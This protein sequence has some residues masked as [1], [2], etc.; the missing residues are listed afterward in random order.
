MYSYCDDTCH[1]ELHWGSTICISLYLMQLLQEIIFRLVQFSVL[2]PKIVLA[3]IVP[4]QSTWQNYLYHHPKSCNYQM[5]GFQETSSANSSC[6]VVVIPWRFPHRQN[7]CSRPPSASADST[8]LHLTNCIRKITTL[9]MWTSHCQ[10]RVLYI[11]RSPP[12]L[13]LRWQFCHPIHCPGWAHLVHQGRCSRRI[14]EKSPLPWM[15]LSG[16]KTYAQQHTHTYK[17]TRWCSSSE[18]LRQKWY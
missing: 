12:T 5:W 9:I 10:N 4:F 3:P 6:A 13:N 15:V 2:P 11:S 16:I 7:L 8:R 1:E 14:L 18:H 17:Y